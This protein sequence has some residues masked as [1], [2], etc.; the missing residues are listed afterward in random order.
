MPM[1]QTQVN[2]LNAGFHIEGLR[3]IDPGLFDPD[4][5]LAEAARR[6]DLDERG[7][8]EWLDKL[9][10]GIHDAVRA[11]VRSA[12]TRDEPQ[13]ITFAWAP[14]FDYEMTVWDVS[15]GP[16]TPGGITILIKS[17]YDR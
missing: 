5:S 8:A 2:A 3:E 15:A 6:L 1:M 12:L 9:P 7:L 11:T 17:P 4:V 16:K 14:A 13:P 10:Q